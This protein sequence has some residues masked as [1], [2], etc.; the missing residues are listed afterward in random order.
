MARDQRQQR[1]MQKE[2]DKEAWIPKTELG[3]SVKK[4]EIK[5][6]DEI[7]NKGL[8]ILE[9]GIVDTLVSN[10]ESEMIEIGQSKG[11]FGGGKRSIW[12]QTQKK[13]KEGNKPKFATMIIVGNKNGYIGIGKGKSKETMPAREKA[14]R[15]AKLNVQKIVRGCGSWECGCGGNHTIPFKIKGKCGSAEITL[16]P[17]PKGVGLCVEK[18][19]RK[20]LE[21]AGVKD[22]YSKTKGK[23]KSKINLMLACFNALKNLSRTKIPERYVKV[24]GIVEGKIKD[25][26]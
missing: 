3:K 7:L 13:T 19:C 23:T 14:T 8:N 17:A 22:V 5:E 4:G 24:G 21:F 11:K 12:R 1:M 9:D 15:Q 2:F 25:G 16:M 20:L 10:L 26:E 6:L 18:Q